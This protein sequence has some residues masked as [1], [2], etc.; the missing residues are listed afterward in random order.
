MKIAPSFR[1]TRNNGIQFDTFN[2][3]AEILRYMRHFRVGSCFVPTPMLVN[4]WSTNRWKVDKCWATIIQ[5]FIRWY[6][7]IRLT[8]LLFLHCFHLQSYLQL[9][10][11]LGHYCFKALFIFSKSVSL[12]RYIITFTRFIYNNISR[13]Q[14]KSIDFPNEPFIPS[15]SFIQWLP[16]NCI[17][18]FLLSIYSLLRLVDINT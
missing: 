4:E 3:S 8:N 1:M 5:N 18:Q 11:F 16:A 15:L 13:I 14:S 17:L 2:I 6:R 12:Y 10:C 7:L 9:F